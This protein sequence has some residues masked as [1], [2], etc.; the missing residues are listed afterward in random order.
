MSI[1]INSG[2]T[3]AASDATLINS[4]EKNTMGAD[5]ITGTLDALNQQG[6]SSGGSSSD[7][8]ASYD[9]QKSV[10]SAAYGVKGAVADITS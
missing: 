9:M 6:A 3:S 8:A 5:I 1:T 4:V 7:M 10:L 2:G